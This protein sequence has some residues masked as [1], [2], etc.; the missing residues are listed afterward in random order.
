[1]AHDLGFRRDLLRDAFIT[2]AAVV[3]ALLALDDITTD[4]ASSFTYER[5]ALAG[6][7]SW[8]VVVGWRFLRRG[9]GAVGGMSLGLVAMAALAQ[10]TIGANLLTS[11]RIDYLVTLGALAWF[12]VLAGI[13]AGEAWRTGKSYAA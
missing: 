3:I 5:I 4:T 6:C 7:G 13:L 12:V 9:R 2:F 8:F 10:R 1:M 11:V